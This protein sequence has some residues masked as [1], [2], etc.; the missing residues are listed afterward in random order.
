V[1]GYV[2]DLPGLAESIRKVDVADGKRDNK[3]LD[4]E[5]LD[6]PTERRDT[7]AWVLYQTKIIEAL[8]TNEGFGS[9]TVPDLFYTNYKQIDE[10]GHNWNMVNVEMREIVEYT[11]AALG[12][13]VDF[14]NRRVGKET[15]V[16]VVT[17]DHGQGPD[18]K[19]IGAWP[20]NMGELTADVGRRFD[21]EPDALITNT[22]PV[23]F[24]VDRAA[25][26]SAGIEV[27]AIADYL[28]DYRLEENAGEQ[29]PPQAYAIRRKEPIFS[30]AF[31]SKSLGRIWE[32]ARR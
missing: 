31:P 4:H 5:I 22:S 1:P 28:I 17:A 32:C 25:L 26:E 7:P 29:G 2:E 3:W 15:W 9:D 21:L 27:E 10:V 19:T 12:Q 23:G 13:L 18:P 24:W 8:L 14:L 6:D 30:A 20:I 11:D 16:M